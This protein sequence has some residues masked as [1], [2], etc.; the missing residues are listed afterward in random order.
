[1]LKSFR[2]YILIIIL[3]FIIPTVYLAVFEIDSLRENERV[4]EEIYTNQLDA[5]LYPINQYS[6]DI[7]KTLGNLM[8]NCLS[9]DTAYRDSCLLQ[10]AERLSSPCQFFL[11]DQS[12]NRCTE[13]I[14]RGKHPVTSGE[15]RQVL[16]DKEQLLTKLAVNYTDWGY[17]KIETIPVNGKYTCL[18]FC[19][20]TGGTNS[21]LAFVLEPKRF[22]DN[23]L[24]P[25]IQEII[26]EEGKLAISVQKLGDKSSI[27]NSE[28]SKE[29]IDPE[30]EKSL[31]LFPE[32]SLGIKLKGSSV[33]EIVRSRTQK[34]LFLIIIIDLILLLGIWLIYR[35]VKKQVELSQL[36][37]DF[38]SNVSHEIRT[39]LALI[40]MY[41]ETLEMG[42]ISTRE[43]IH[44]YYTVI[45]QETRRLTSIVNKILNFSQIESGKRKYIMEH[46]D[47]NEVVRAIADSY[48][49]RI[50]KD[51]FT[52]TQKLQE[53]IPGIE[54]D[55]EALADAIINLIDNAIKYSDQDKYIELETYRKGSMVV[56]AITDHGI[57]ISPT[58][59]KYIFDKFYRVTEKNIALRSKGSGLG[60]AI[61]KHIMDAHGGKINLESTKGRGSRF[62]L[63]FP[64]LKTS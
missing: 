59:Q 47:L 9:E 7:F 51:G 41:I 43:K 30:Y 36:K 50:E 33:S 21:F 38:V 35:N 61:V 58:E 19:V 34:N 46:A 1:M 12:G 25:Y 54:A 42:R 24:M 4:I 23:E 13:L 2:R 32:Y 6:D 15:L 27:T 17:Q 28:R 53:D 37:S 14:D 40:T 3:I 49:I 48:S 44:E 5:I 22:I 56:F 8:Q 26:G 11:Y 18:L 52:C 60:L 20:G 16:I 10:H 57:G 62:E 39:P 31:W 55:K 45:L 63:H 29:S 64:Q